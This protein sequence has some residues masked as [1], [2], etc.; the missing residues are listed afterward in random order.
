MC[1]RAERSQTGSRAHL[2]GLLGA[3][4]DGAADEAAG[5]GNGEDGAESSMVRV[6]CAQRDR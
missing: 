1:V 5:G 3:A 2:S 6:V 4:G